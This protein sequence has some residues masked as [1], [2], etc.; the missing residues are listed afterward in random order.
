MIYEFAL[1]QN[2]PN[3][4]NPTT[5]IKF[6]IPGVEDENFRPLR[7]HLVVYD[8]LGREVAVLVNQKLQPGNHEV[9]FNGS[10]LSSGIYFYKIQTS[11]GF[12]STKKLMLLK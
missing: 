1:E 7:T 12:L 11:S 2:Y 5:T 10:S 9:T 4:F 8:I 6:T 3:P